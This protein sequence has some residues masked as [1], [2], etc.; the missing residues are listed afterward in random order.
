MAGSSELSQDPVTTQV[1]EDNDGKEIAFIHPASDESVSLVINASIDSGDGRSDWVWVRLT[2]GTLVLGVFPQGDTYFAVEED[3]VFPGV[4]TR[5]FVVAFAPATTD[6]GAGGFRWYPDQTEA[7]D[8]LR[9]TLKENR[10]DV[11][12]HSFTISPI[13]VPFPRSDREAI[14]RWLDSNQHLFEPGLPS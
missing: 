12:T 13:V 2:D 10:G 14:S 6:G 7:I 11:L 5:V 3:A 4:A 1:V 8:S 9:A